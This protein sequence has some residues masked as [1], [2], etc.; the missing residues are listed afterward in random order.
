MTGPLTQVSR[1][2]PFREYSFAVT[3]GY[4]KQGHQGSCDLERDD[5]GNGGFWSSRDSDRGSDVTILLRSWAS[6]CSAIGA[7]CSYDETATLS[8]GDL[9]DHAFITDSKR[10]AS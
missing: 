10:A 1:A 8:D 3:G 4:V 9:S 6:P 2:R 5:A 7:I